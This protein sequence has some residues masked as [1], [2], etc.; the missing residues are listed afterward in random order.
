MTKLAEFIGTHFVF[1][2][3]LLLGAFLFI[4]YLGASSGNQLHMFFGLSSANLV[5]M[6]II[7]HEKR[8]K[9]DK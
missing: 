1:I 5:I 2:N 8:N 7:L 3:L 6:H 4:G 9:A